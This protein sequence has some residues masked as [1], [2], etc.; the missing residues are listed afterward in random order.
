M[1]NYEYHQSI[2]FHIEDT[3]EVFVLYHRKDSN[4]R[5]EMFTLSSYKI[6]NN[7]PEITKGAF[8]YSTANDCFKHISINFSKRKKC[9]IKEVK[10]PEG[11]TFVTIDE[12]KKLLQK[13]GFDPK[14]SSS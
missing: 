10:N 12:Q 7:I 5:L 3:I 1:H 2:E 14:I 13:Y 8:T 11:V 6:E 9:Q 4:V